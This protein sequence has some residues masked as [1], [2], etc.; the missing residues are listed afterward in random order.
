MR[1]LTDIRHATQ[2]VVAVVLGV[3]ISTLR[4]WKEAPRNM[5]KTYDLPV[6]VAWRIAGQLADLEG[7]SGTGEKSK[8]LEAWR[9]WKCKQAQLDYERACGQLV[10]V[11]D[12]KIE[13]GRA[14]DAC[15]RRLLSLPGSMAAR[16]QGLPV[17]QCAQAL[18]VEVR[19]ALS[20]LAEAL[21]VEDRKLVKEET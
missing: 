14:V 10:K 17:E 2:E 13:T 8:A 19:D 21:R 11:E 20:E 3:A 9:E 5:D 4:S 7:E 16:V 1:K 15:K 6:I 12:V 18:E